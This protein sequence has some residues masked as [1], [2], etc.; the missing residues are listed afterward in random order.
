MRVL[1][2]GEGSETASVGEGLEAAGVAVERRVADSAAAGGSEEVLEIAH[3]LLDLER[4]LS[5]QRADAVLV[6]S[7][8]SAALAATIV[9]TKLGTPV[10]RLELS[11][12]ATP[13]D[14][15]ARVIR[16]LADTALA[17]DHAAIVNWLRGGYSPRA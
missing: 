15:N 3:D 14:A 16:Q 11:G 6:V 2:V 5:E 12:D 17:P 10:A 9:A 13:E 4:A 7:P 1:I 8:S